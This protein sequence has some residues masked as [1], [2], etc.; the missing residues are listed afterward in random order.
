MTEKSTPDP[1]SVTLPSGAPMP[2]VGFGTWRLSGRDSYRAVR[3]ALDAGY[4]LIDTATMYG[5]E[6][7]IGAAIRDSGIARESLFVTTKLPAE[8]AGRERATIDA[9]LAALG[10]DRVDLWLVHWPPAERVLVRTWEHLLAVR[11]DGLTTDVGVSNYNIEQIDR[12]IAATDEA[13]A[14]NQIP[15][16]PAGFDGELLRALRERSVVLEGYSPF[17]HSNLKDRALV[18]IARRHGV[19]SAQVIVRWHVQHEIVVIPK[20]AKP[21]RIAAN[22]DVWDFGLAPDEMRVLDDLGR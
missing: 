7:E 20:S 2:L 1:A 19:S 22:F 6:S 15:W 9:S 18:E 14:V 16:A 10:L 3:S 4:R 5:N 21:D 11:D 13:P 12:L 8:D 17:K